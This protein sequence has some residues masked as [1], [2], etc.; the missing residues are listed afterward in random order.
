MDY[1]VI[2]HNDPTSYISEIYRQLR[3]HVEFLSSDNDYKV[4]NITSTVAGEG[5]TLTL[6]NLA[7]VLAQN[8]KRVLI[9]DLDLRRP[10]IHR[11]FSKKNDL[12]VTDLLLSN[13]DDN[14]ILHKHDSGFY[15]LFAGQK[16]NF[17][18]EVLSSMKLKKLIESLK[19][20]FDYILLDGP[21]LAL[22]T[23]SIIIS[24]Y[25]DATIYVVKSNEVN[26]KLVKKCI[27]TLEESKANL[28]GLVLTNAPKSDQ[29]KYGYY[30]E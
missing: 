15:G 2:S 3:T 23:D 11:A 20:K 4:L 16:T 6:M 1:K 21:P 14:E 19:D 17:S 7:T 8:D 29:N 30:Y 13:I 5:K 12:G 26:K 25:S 18:S 22:V 28:L 10:K 24:S 9:I 27:H